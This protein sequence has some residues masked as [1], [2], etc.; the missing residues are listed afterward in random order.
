M[1]LMAKP[2]AYILAAA[3]LPAP[4]GTFAGDAKLDEA[5]S[6]LWQQY[7]AKFIDPS[8]RVIDNANGGISHS[9]GQGY[10]MLL[11]E[12]FGDKDA[13]ANAWLWTQRKSFGPSGPAC[14]LAMGSDLDVACD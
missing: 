12:R 13:F 2:T 14:R 11:A 3:I 5:L 9:E 8:G 7:K 4:H 1:M 10:S 6:A